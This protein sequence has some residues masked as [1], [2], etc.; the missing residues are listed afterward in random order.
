MN[1]LLYLTY[2]IS[3]IFLYK[4]LHYSLMFQQYKRT[5]NQIIPL[6]KNVCFY[7]NLIISIF[8]FTFFIN[9]CERTNKYL[10][11]YSI[12]LYI[13]CVFQCITPLY[14]FIHFCGF[15]IWTFSSLA[16][17]WFHSHYLL[18]IVFLSFMY[19]FVV[20]Y[21]YSLIFQTILISISLYPALISSKCMNE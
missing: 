20:S 15:T 21:R 6:F 4:A 8:H 9:E 1:F 3:V 7:M 12:S 18:L 2:L 16:L 13:I 14:T 17:F 5:I 11:M 19:L 10:D